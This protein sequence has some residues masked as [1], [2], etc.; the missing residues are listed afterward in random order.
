MG[1]VDGAD[2]VAD[3]SSQGPRVGDGALKPELTAPGVDI[4]AARSRYAP[5]GSGSYQTL[6]GTSMAA[7][8][9]PVPP[10]SWR[11]PAQD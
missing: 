6:S 5:E 9:S 4:L 2:S 7:P 3:F 10:P 1:A 8:T 11:A